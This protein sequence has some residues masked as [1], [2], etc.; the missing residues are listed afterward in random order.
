MQVIQS[1]Y[2]SVSSSLAELSSVTAY[3]HAAQQQATAAT[4][5]LEQLQHLLQAQAET[6]AVGSSSSSGAAVSRRTKHPQQQ[7][8]PTF[9]DSSGDLASDSHTKIMDET[10]A[11]LEVEVAALRLQLQR[12]EVEVQQLM[13]R[14]KHLLSGTAELIPAAMLSAARSQQDDLTAQ[15]AA[16]QQQLQQQAAAQQYAAEVYVDRV[17]ARY[18]VQRLVEAWLIWRLAAAQG[19]VSRVDWGFVLVALSLLQHCH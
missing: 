11:A 13:T 6:A 17:V 9:M 15:V 8:E 19:R 1:C 2:V 7:H 16:L 12:R 3:L 14:E 10:I 4:S 5:Q 18:K